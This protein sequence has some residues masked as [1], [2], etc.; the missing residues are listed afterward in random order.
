MVNVA[1]IWDTLEGTYG[2]AWLANW[3]GFERVDVLLSMA[4]LFAGLA[5][6][7]VDWALRH[8][9]DRVPSLPAFKKLAESAGAAGEV[10]EGMEW[11]WV[12]LPIKGLPRVGQPTMKPKLMPIGSGYTPLYG[13]P[14]EEP[15]LTNAQ[16]ARGAAYMAQ[17]WAAL[18][19]DE[20]ADKARAR[21]AELVEL[22]RDAGENT[23]TA[24]ALQDEAERD[25]ATA[26]AR[27]IAEETQGMTEPQ[28]ET[29]AADA[30][31]DGAEN[32][33]W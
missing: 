33:P 14:K 17:T 18:G 2:N 5:D 6:G 15:P 1:K 26:R 22:A 9:P 3:R 13:L 4:E 7:Q 25:F 28:P 12:P 32:L 23:P 31:F 10:P 24:A 30:Q 11:V 27:R 8:L 19:D 21:C 29:P 20:R 16:R